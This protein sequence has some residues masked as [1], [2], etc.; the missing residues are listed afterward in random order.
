LREK[1]DFAAVG[2]FREMRQA[3][4]PLM[5]WKGAFD[6]GIERVRIGMES[7]M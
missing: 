1:Y 2:A 5:R 4:C 3:L 6:E 7:G